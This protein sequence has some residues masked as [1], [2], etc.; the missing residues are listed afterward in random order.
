MET[1]T[2]SPKFQIVIP[3]F[4][5]NSLRI[6]PGEKIVMYEKDGVIHM[7]RIQ[8]IKNL[9]GKLKKLTTINLRDENERFAQ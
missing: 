7:V 6:C 5:R 8:K 4:I 2:I 1:V 9:K 3:K